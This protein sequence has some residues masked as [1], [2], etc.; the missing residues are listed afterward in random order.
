MLF[1]YRLIG[2]ALLDRSIYEGIESDRRALPQAMATVLLSSAAA[3]VGIAGWRGPDPA[4]MAAAAALALV[5]WA[6]WATLMFQIGGRIM[7]ARETDTSLGELLRTIGFAA[8]P[9]LLQA[10]GAFPHMT[11][12]MFLVAWIWMFAATVV[13]VRQALDYGSLARTLVVC[14]IAAGL[15]LGMALV[16]GLVLAPEVR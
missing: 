2:A 1:G 14:A 4:V 8:A 15:S 16:I 11:V 5:T 3:G 6:A 13:A 10:L 7:P 12:P 9:G